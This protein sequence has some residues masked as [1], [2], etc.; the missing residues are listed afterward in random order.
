MN[1]YDTI[2]ALSTP[3]GKGGIAVIRI[4]GAEAIEIAERVFRPK[5]KK[6][7]IPFQEPAF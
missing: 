7:L 1:F 3:V 5:N 4:A 2:A 6:R